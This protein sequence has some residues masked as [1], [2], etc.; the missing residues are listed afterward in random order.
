MKGYKIRLSVLLLI[1]STL[2]VFAKRKNNRPNF[3]VIVVDDM[4]YS[5]L[6]CFGSE[7]RTPNIDKLA[8]VGVINTNFHTSALCAP[9]R[10]MLLSG[11]DNHEAGMGTMEEVYTYDK[12]NGAPEYAGVL[13][14]DI[15]TIP[16]ILQLNGYETMMSG[17][18]HLGDDK[19]HWP[20]DRGFDHSFSLLKGGGSHFSDRRGLMRR[21]DPLPY[22][23]D[24]MLLDSLPKGF[25][26]SKNYTD[27]MLSYLR[28]NSGS[29]KPFFA[30]LAYTAPHDPVQVPDAWLNR[31]KGV[32]DEGYDVL[33]QQRLRGAVNSGVASSNSKVPDEHRNYERW[34]DLPLDRQKYL[35]RSMELYASMIEYMD[36]QIGRVISFLEKSKELENTYIIFVSDNGSNPKSHDFYSKLVD[37]MAYLDGFN[38]SYNNMG[39]IGSFASIEYGFA[40][41]TNMPKHYVKTTSGEGGV[42]T[43]F[44]IMGPKVEGQGRIKRELITSMDVK[45]T[46]LDLA[47]V[48]SPKEYEGNTII[49]DRGVSLKQYFEGERDCPHAKGYIVA[50]EIFGTRYIRCGDYKLT[51]IGSAMHY[52][53]D[54]W[55]LYNLK[56]DPSETIDIS[57]S[58]PDIVKDLLIKWK[59]YK[60][61]VGIIDY[62]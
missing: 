29:G 5:D 38:L 23:E 58:H 62:L 54:I 53:D 30:Y 47:G 11:C 57:R 40:Q 59:E 61:E 39:K 22:V 15:T 21:D 60:E 7:I 24:D 34:N 51:N 3:L 43:P 20:V 44:I 45:P 48:K 42:N 31:Y 25:Y 17:K 35:S 37:D 50:H 18:W 19:G 13:S 9:S 55:R 4:G 49:A 28:E 6:G 12:Q 46:I 8:A 27:K 32:Y 10:S 56:D 16:E 36:D 1:L 33:A 26:S 41:A 14:E 2:G 52:G